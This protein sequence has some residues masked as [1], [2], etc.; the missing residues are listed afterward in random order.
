MTCA[1]LSQYS[2]QRSVPL[3]S[4]YKDEWPD[5]QPHV[6][7]C[8]PAVSVPTS[9]PLSPP[10]VATTDIPTADNAAYD[11]ATQVPRAPPEK[12]WQY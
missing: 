2:Q 12:S 1:L 7:D 5:E 4:V 8:V 11:V 9:L 10:S 6:Y 3:S